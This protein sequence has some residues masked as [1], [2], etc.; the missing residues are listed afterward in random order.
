VVYS[1]SYPGHIRFWLTSLIVGRGKLYAQFNGKSIF[2]A[3]VFIFEVGSAVCGTAPNIDA[4]I[5]GKIICG[6]K[7]IGIY[8]GAL[9]LLAV[10]TNNKERPVYISY[11]SIVW[12]TGTVLGP[13]VGGA[14]IN[15]SAT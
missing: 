7:K 1:C 8:I 5:I 4:L 2:L 15:S 13:V 12:G 14:F 11:I 10:T 9:N 6:A 3:S